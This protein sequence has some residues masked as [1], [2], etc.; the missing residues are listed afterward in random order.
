M[1]P[2]YSI[3]ERTPVKPA[4]LNIKKK[5]YFSSK[6]MIKPF[7]SLEQEFTKSKRLDTFGKLVSSKN[8]LAE[9]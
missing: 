4:P 1:R 3:M 5:T 8:A 7:E 9:D 6:S 2:K